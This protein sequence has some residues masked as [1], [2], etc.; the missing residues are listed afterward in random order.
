MSSQWLPSSAC[1]RMP[2]RSLCSGTKP[3]TV[4]TALVQASTAD[5]ARQHHQIGRPTMTCISTRLT[6]TARARHCFLVLLKQNPQVVLDGLLHDER[7]EEDDG[8]ALSS[9]THEQHRHRKAF[10]NQECQR[11]WARPAH[12]RVAGGF[13]RRARDRGRS[14]SLIFSRWTDDC[15]RPR[16]RPTVRAT[17][18]GAQCGAVDNLNR[19]LPL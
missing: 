14:L 17:V 13:T 15:D 9:A 12:W 16:L 8:P 6:T 1:R 5:V 18:G 11:Y 10:G 7:K 3:E 4:A 19:E 2:C